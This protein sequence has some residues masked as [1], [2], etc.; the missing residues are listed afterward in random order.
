MKADYYR[1]DVVSSSAQMITCDV[2]YIPLQLSFRVSIVYAYNTREERRE[3]WDEIEMQS[4]ACLKPWLLLGDFNSVLHMDD[5][6]GGN[7]VTLPKVTDF[8]NCINTSGL[9]EVPHQGQKYTWNDRSSDRRIFSKID[10]MFINAEWLN[11]MP[12]CRAVYL[13]E[14]ISD[15]FPARISLRKQATRV[16]RAFQYCNVWSQHPQFKDKVQTVW[17]TQIE[18]CKM[19]KVVR[20]LKLLKKSLK[21]LNTQD[22]RNI[23]TEAVE[24]KIALDKAQEKLQ[25]DPLNMLL[26]QEERAQYTKYRHTS[27]MAEMFLQQQSKATWL[28]LGDDCT[29]YFFA[30]IRHRRLQQAITQLKDDQ[31]INKSPGPDGYSSG[32]F[33]AA[34]EIIG[35]DVIEA[36]LDFFRNDKLLKQLNTTNIALIPK[37]PGPEFASQFRPISCCNVLYKCITKMICMRLKSVVDHFVADNQSAFVQGRFML[38]NVLICHDLLRHYNRQ[39]TPRC[40]MKIDLRKAYDMVSWEFVEEALNGYGFPRRFI[41]LVMNCISSPMFTV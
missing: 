34:W 16:K 37:I 4:I 20:K 2:V 9:L 29:K 14:G 31:D 22:F 8:Q 41:E 19:W 30:V 23:V 27:Y 10:W 1:V 28:K 38:H 13:A 24:D 26:Q 12:S 11:T 5:R 33:K 7:P 40:L 3:L 21:E 39:T 32:F 36:V 15:H 6:L 35:K 17:N 25:A 18:G